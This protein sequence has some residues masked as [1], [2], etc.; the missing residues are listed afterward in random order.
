MLELQNTTSALAEEI[1]FL[2]LFLRKKWIP[3][4]GCSIDF[5]Q[6]SLEYLRHFTC[7]S[8]QLKQSKAYSKSHLDENGDFDVELSPEKDSLLRCRIQS[9]HQNRTKYYLCIKYDT[10]DSDEPI[11]DN[12]CQYKCGNRTIGCCAQTAT[13]LWYIGYPCFTEWRQS[14][15]GTI[16]FDSIV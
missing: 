11:L 10:L 3:M 8:Y 6:L 4:K 5:P 7:D 15:R 1:T 12:Y 9:R 13:V 16:L 2:R 14:Q